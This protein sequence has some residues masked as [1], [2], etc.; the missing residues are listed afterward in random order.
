MLAEL[1]PCFPGLEYLQRLTGLSERMVEY[2]LAALRET[3]L[4][5]YIVKGTRKRGEAPQA[6][7]FA[8]MIPVEFDEALGI[9]T[10]AG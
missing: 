4:L 9:R 10:G 5:A 2:H 7:E 3:G 6:S 1:S 8:R